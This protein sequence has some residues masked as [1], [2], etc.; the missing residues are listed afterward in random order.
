MT[1][2]LRRG[3]AVVSGFVAV[4]ACL[5]GVELLTGWPREQPAAWLEGTP[6]DSYRV[7][8]L[9]LGG[10]VG[11]SAALASWSA[12][13]QRRRWPEAS[14]LAGAVLAG[15]TVAE[16]GMLN[17]PEAPT[18]IE[19]WYGGLGAALIAAGASA[20]RRAAIEQGHGERTRRGGGDRG[21]QRHRAGVRGAARGRR[22]RRGA[23]RTSYR[24]AHRDRAPLR[25]R[26]GDL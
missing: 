3:S 2:A 22:V 19:W 18:P 8:G 5:G 11:G 7:P 6:F 20:R 23:R 1:G 17:Q 4:T 24:Q 16:V 15:W 9:L 13:R 26:A 12:V 25:G 14:A 21:E 10:L